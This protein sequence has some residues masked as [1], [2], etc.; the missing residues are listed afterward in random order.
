MISGPPF[1]Q[2]QS[3]GC[4]DAHQAAVAL[5]GIPTVGKIVLMELH[6]FLWDAALPTREEWQAGIT[7]YGFDLAINERLDVRHN[8][9]FSPATFCGKKSG[10]EFDLCPTNDITSRHIGISERIGTRGLSA[11]FRWGGNVLESV[12]VYVASAVLARLAD[13]IVYYPQK[14]HFSTGHEAMSMARR[15]MAATELY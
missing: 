12:V 6:V 15:L 9:G 1:Y 11:N 2:T 4:G 7:E 8:T 14:N 10:F 3:T 5:S 13:G